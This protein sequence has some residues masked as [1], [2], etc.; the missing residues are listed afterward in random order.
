M[1]DPE[2]GKMMQRE[3]PDVDP[4]REALVK[5]WLDDV[6]AARAHW[7]KD[8]ERMRRNMKFAGGKQWPNQKTE[9]DRFMVNLVQ[10]VIKSTVA[11]LYAKNPKVIAKRRDRMDFKVWDGR[12]ETIQQA[13]QSL[14]MAS[15]VAMT[16][17]LGNPAMDAT[18]Q[19][20]Q[21]V[22]M[23]FQQGT[24]RRTML[25]KVGKTLVLLMDYYLSE[26]EPGFKLQMKQMVRRARTTGVGY[27]KLGFQREMELSETQDRQLADMAARLALIGRLS[28]DLADGEID[29]YAAEAEELR[30]ATAALQS[31]PEVVVREGL[32]YDFP[33]STRI[34]P[35]ISTEK[36]MGWV[37]S[38]WVAE[39]IM[40]SADR[41][42]E[43]YGVDLGKS[44]KPYRTVAG[45]PE[46]GET[47]RISDHRKGLAC[48]F[49]VYDKATGMQ[50]VVCEGYPDFLAEP[51]PPP[52]FIEQFFPYFAVTFND[53]EDEG[54][55]FP[56]SDVEL[57]THIQKEYNR[58]KEALRQHR[59]ANRPLYFSPKGAFE[60]DEV[61]AL[62]NYAAHS[63]VQLNGLEK[64]R[65]VTDLIAPV[66]KHGV[67]PNLYETG[68]LF[69]DIMRVTGNAEANIGGTGSSSATE[70]N[71]AEA[72]RQG[73][74]GL[75]SDDLDEMLTSLFRASGSVLLDQ[76][77]VETV[78]ELVG[79][80]AVWP[81]LSRAEIAREV[82]LEVK[83]G[84][85][86]RPNQAR[87]AANFERIYPLLVQVPGVSPR[88]LAERAVQI[89]DDDVDVSDAI[90]DGMP[91]I[92]AQ[93][94]LKQLPTGDPATEP[95]AQGER[96][97]DPQ[98]QRET[99][100]RA[101]PGFPGAG[102]GGS[103]M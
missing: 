56:K 88:W 34:I 65:P 90:I 100:N 20:A 53:V 77:T 67:D 80:G 103:G 44:F 86:G 11:S 49:H 33:H 71:I 54:E 4:S 21:A 7:G 79:E 63:V 68:S 27:V 2:P 42:K 9:D 64:G 95:T 35:S 22:L 60:E 32:T 91:S 75:D 3:R 66:M 24:Q 82:W 101:Q 94:A 10:R 23:D 13:Q 25:E 31:E 6:L 81:Q 48:V 39:E 26:N 61:Q 59:I 29:P 36:L 72:S 46:G 8:F 57:L 93:N 50:F 14:M 47:R 99:G 40:L 30:L 1:T 16:G 51:A 28:A 41:V 78:R 58:S 45:S 76:L 19:Q 84:S 74:L 69:E 43:L 83:G 87:E 70:S 96:G 85:S 92:I 17:A 5:R 55:L 89:A 97:N 18:V 62:T 12:A 98:G 52:V 37:G 38:E 102:A 73:S 15:Q